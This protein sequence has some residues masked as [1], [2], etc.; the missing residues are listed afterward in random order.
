MYPHN[1]TTIH[2]K[3]VYTKHQ[4][5]AVDKPTA[6]LKKV[7]SESWPHQSYLSISNH[8][9]TKTWIEKTNQL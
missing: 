3:Y 4:G 9:S 8:Q 1:S 6:Q 7:A 2:M 5:I